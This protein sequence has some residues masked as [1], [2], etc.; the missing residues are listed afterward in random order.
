MFHYKVNSN[1]SHYKVQNSLSG[2]AGTATV[3]PKDGSILRLSL[4][5]DMDSANP[6]LVA[7]L[8]VEYGTE[9]LGNSPYI[10]PKRSVALSQ[11]L[12]QQWVNDVVFNNYHLFHA[13]TRLLSGSTPRGV[14]YAVAGTRT[15]A[16]AACM[17]AFA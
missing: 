17:F 8:M 3:D 16:R 11:G 4:K 10:C 13:S 9:I 5:A 6:F 12:R 1:H 7:D 14:K 15:R 2:Y